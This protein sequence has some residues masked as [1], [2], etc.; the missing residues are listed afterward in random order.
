WIIN[1]V[2]RSCVHLVRHY[3]SNLVS[4][5]DDCFASPSIIIKGMGSCELQHYL[6]IF[7]GIRIQ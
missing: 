6:R 7:L 3:F 1:E 2:L 5:K 4:I